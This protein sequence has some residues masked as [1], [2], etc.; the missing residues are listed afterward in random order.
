MDKRDRIGNLIEEGRN[1]KKEHQ[2]ATDRAAS[3]GIIRVG[4]V[5]KGTKGFEKWVGNV[6]TAS[7]RHFSD[8]PLYDELGGA[9]FHKRFSE[10]LGFLESIYDDREYFEDFITP[11]VEVDDTRIIEDQMAPI[12]KEGIDR[13]YKMEPLSSLHELLIE[14]VKSEAPV[15]LLAKKFE[16]LSKKDDEKLRATLREL[17]ERGYIDSIKWAD[18]LPYLINLNYSA[19]SYVDELLRTAQERKDSTASEKKPASDNS[20]VFIVH[21]HDSGSKNEVARLIAQLNLEPIILHEQPNMGMTIIEKI[22]DN[23]DVGFAIILYTPC[24]EGKPKGTDEYRERARQNVVFEHG[25]FS[26][27]LGRNRVCALVRDS[28]EIPSDL[29]GIVYIPMDTNGAWK[30]LVVGEMQAVGYNVSKDRIQ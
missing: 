1:V 13:I 11:I 17:R 22:E 10:I 25:Y 14:I 12:T 8:H 20:K 16:G 28:V 6:K 7:L 3:Q 30:Y 18:N 26:G 2:I 21:G 24:D 19:Y 15:K 27:L 4:G 9:L 29:N 23:S 5:G